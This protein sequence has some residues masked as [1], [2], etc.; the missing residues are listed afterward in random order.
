MGETNPPRLGAAL[1][2]LCLLL[3]ATPAEAREARWERFAVVVGA[4]RGATG[5][6]TLRYAERDAAKVADL[7]AEV[8]GIPLSRIY[9]LTG[10]DADTVRTH[11]Q[12]IETE[13]AAL[14]REANTIG[15]KANDAS[16][17]HVVVQM[18]DEIERLREQ[19]Q[20]VE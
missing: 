15:S 12:E 7:L 2:A 8:G 13:I 10:V 14:N 1:A 9:L 17:A 5:S 19:V 16:I 20:N 6:D 3:I 4:D 11:L 18:K